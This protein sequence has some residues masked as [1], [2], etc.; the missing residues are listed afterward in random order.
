VTVE[1]E[2]ETVFTSLFVSKI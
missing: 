1:A 2:D